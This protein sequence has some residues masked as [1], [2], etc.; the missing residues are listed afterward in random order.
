MLVFR[1][2]DILATAFYVSIMQ[3]DRSVLPIDQQ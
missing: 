3:L 1:A 2:R